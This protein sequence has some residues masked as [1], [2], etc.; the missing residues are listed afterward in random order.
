MEIKRI[1]L[2]GILIDLILTDKNFAELESKVL[3]EHNEFLFKT[4]YNDK[5]NWIKIKIPKYDKKIENIYFEYQIDSKIFLNENISIIE[6]FKILN[7]SIEKQPNHL[8][9]IKIKTAND[10]LK[11]L[12]YEHNSFGTTEK[13]N[14]NILRINYLSNEIVN[15]IKD[16]N[17]ILNQE[18]V[19]S[20]K[21]KCY[22]FD[23]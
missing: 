21:L 14:I 18:Y 8:P 20:I 5:H 16:N 10:I 9:V 6:V 17:K 23:K 12:V 4:P 2:I 15:F 19:D 7:Y 13:S 11:D 1:K 3:K 22:D